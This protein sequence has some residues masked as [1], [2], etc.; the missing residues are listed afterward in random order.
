M[1]N[2]QL[3]TGFSELIEFSLQQNIISCVVCS[4]TVLQMNSTPQPILLNEILHQ[5]VNSRPHAGRIEI[6]K[7]LASHSPCEDKN[8]CWFYL[9]NHNKQIEITCHVCLTS[10]KITNYSPSNFLKAHSSQIRFTESHNHRNNIKT[11]NNRKSNYNTFQKPKILSGQELSLSNFF[12]FFFI[13]ILILKFD[14]LD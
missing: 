7:T 8:I 4:S 10:R 13:S 5:H 11:W 3:K 9:G 1:Q 2:R 14:L 6:I 12:L